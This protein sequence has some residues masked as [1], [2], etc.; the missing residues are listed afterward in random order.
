MV[1]KLFKHEALSYLR[2]VIPVQ[3][4]LL[5]VAVL[6]RILQFFETDTT[7]YDI[8]S[9]SSVFAFVV[10]VTVTLVMTTIFSIVRFYR[11]MFTGEGYLTFTLPVTPTQHL[12]VKLLTAFL[13]QVVNVLVAAVSVCIITAGDVLTEVVRAGDYLLTN[14][15]TELKENSFHLWLYLLEG[16]L[17][18]IVLELASVLFYYLCI[19]IGQLFKKNRVLGAVG[20]YFI[21]YVVT[22]V[23]STISMILIVFLQETDLFQNIMKY[24]GDHPFATIHI[25]LCGLLVLAAVL[26]V[27]YFFVT[28]R[29]I[30]KKLNLE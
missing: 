27:I 10:A 21:F 16:I 19:A 8:V 3:I 17:L 30:T 9:G 22:Q 6:A 4:I 11:N 26:G 7:A 13:F 1:K 24:I 2:V 20:V 29:I 15:I 14:L 18:L 28:R 23:L 12:L 25:A 5:S